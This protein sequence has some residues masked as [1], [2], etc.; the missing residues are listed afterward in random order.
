MDEIM[1]HLRRYSGTLGDYS[2]FNSIL[3][4]TQNPDATIV[5]SRDEW[6]YFGRTVG[7][8]AKPISI[9]YPVGVPRRDSLGRVKKFIEDRKAEGLSDE[10][11]DQLVMEKFN[12]QG[13]GT[14]FVFSFGKVYDIS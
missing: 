9:L 1:L 6:K 7:E 10:A 2:A 3:I 12:L 11:I 4:A 8:N 13:G 14:A 5:R